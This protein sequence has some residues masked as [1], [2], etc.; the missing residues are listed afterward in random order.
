MWDCV[1]IL[2]LVKE[3]PMEA[4]APVPKYLLDQSEWYAREARSNKKVFYWMRGFQVSIASLIPIVSLAGPW[5]VGRYVSAIL[6]ASI[7]IIE[8]LQQLGQYQQNWHRYRAAREALKREQ[9]LYEMGAGPYS[10]SPDRLRLFVERADSVLGGE[11]SK[12]ITWAERSESGGAQGQ[13]AKRV[14]Q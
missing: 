8:G 13:T 2:S 4:N 12:W 14:S 5:S 7:A 9:F 10:T 11:A 1:P 3:A 6:G